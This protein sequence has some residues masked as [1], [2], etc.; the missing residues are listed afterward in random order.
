MSKDRIEPCKFYICAGQCIYKD[1]CP[2][3]CM[4]IEDSIIPSLYASDDISSEKYINLLDN[5]VKL[6]R[7]L[8]F[9]PV[10]ED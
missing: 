2:P 7:N 4:S 1:G 6:I 3:M 8:G 9:N 5:Y 10:L